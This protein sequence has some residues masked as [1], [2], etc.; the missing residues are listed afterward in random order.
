MTT[1]LVI[2]EVDDV[3]RWL[4]STNREALFGPAGITARTFVERLKTQRVGLIV[5]AP[6]FD[7][8]QRVLGSEAAAEAMSSDGVRAGGM[9]ILVDSAEAH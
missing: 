3:D 2:H 9:L 7:T 1:I 6:D 8:F 5:E 4:A